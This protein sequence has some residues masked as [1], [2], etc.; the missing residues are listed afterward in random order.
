MSLSRIGD[1]SQRLSIPPW[2]AIMLHAAGAAV[3][4][5]YP[6]GSGSPEPRP[7]RAM[8]VSARGADEHWN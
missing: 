5:S 7:S 2:L 8:R 4:L 3:V 1:L 6:P